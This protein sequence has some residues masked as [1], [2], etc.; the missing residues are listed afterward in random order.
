MDNQCEY[1][2]QICICGRLVVEEDPFYVGPDVL[3]EE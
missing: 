2:G 3:D 1:C